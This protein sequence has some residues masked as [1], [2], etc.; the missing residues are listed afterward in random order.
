METELSPLLKDRL[1][2]PLWRLNNL[3]WITDKS[4][5]RVKFQ[6]NWAQ[7]GLYEDLHYLNLILKARQL[8]FTTLTQLIMLD[9]CVFNSDIRAGAIAHT[10]EDAE[11]FFKDKVKYPY[12]NLPDAIKAANPATQDSAR[13]LS[14]KNNSS[15]RVGTSMRSGTLQYLHV[16]EYGKICAKYPDKA[17]EIRTGALNTVQAGQMIFIESTAEGNEGDFYDK[18]QEAQSAARK[19]SALSELDFKF[20][21]FPWWKHQEYVLDPT[22]VVIDADMEAYFSKL[23]DEHGIEL[24]DEQKAWYV[25]KSAQ[26]TEDDMK[27][28]FPATPEEAFE[29]SVEGA[30]YGS[31]MAKLERMGRITNVPHDPAL[32]V[33]VWFDL[34]VNDSMA[35]WFIQRAGPALHIINYYENSGEGLAHYAAHMDQ[36]RREEGYHYGDIVWPHDGNHRVMDEHARKKSEIM[37]GLGY[38]PAIVPRGDLMSGIQLTRLMLARCWFDEKNTAKG[39]RALTNYKK[40]WDDARGTWKR[41][42]AHT[43]ASHGADALRT[44]CN[45]QPFDDEDYGLHGYDEY[46]DGRSAVGG[47]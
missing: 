41:T 2:D 30:Y 35:L 33:E 47:Y 21:F 19:G 1:S 15:I 6:M 45:Y 44:G 34:G 26:Q 43:W 40:E 11:A 18:C 17:K 27:R 20:F 7:A 37:A 39:R 36:L 10:R 24:T 13:M 3:Y 32:P 38:E 25:K 42:P 22:G 9:A 4:G 31:E 8:G 28:E 46:D 5:N 14:F 12:D 29:A 16:S 23:R